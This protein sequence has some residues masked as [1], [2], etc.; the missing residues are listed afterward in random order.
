MCG[1]GVVEH[2]I[3]SFNNACSLLFIITDDVEDEEEEDDDD[4]HELLFNEPFVV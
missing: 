4:E 1:V 2:S 3:E